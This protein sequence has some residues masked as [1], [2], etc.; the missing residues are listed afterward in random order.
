VTHLCQVKVARYSSHIGFC[1]QF[2]SKPLVTSKLKSQAI[3]LLSV[4]KK[5]GYSLTFYN[6]IHALTAQLSPL[7]TSSKARH[8]HRA[9]RNI[10]VDAIAR[11]KPEV[12]QIDL[13]I[14]QGLTIYDFRRKWKKLQATSFKLQAERKKPIPPKS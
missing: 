1:I 4:N 11:H 14:E 8:K 13:N 2:K 6:L 3:V 7:K 12:R 5:S 9:K 10:N